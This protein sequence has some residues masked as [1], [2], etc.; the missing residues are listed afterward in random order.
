MKDILSFFLLTFVGRC[1]AYPSGAPAGVCDSLMPNHGQDP[2]D[3]ISPFHLITSATSLESGETLRIQ[4]QADDGISFKG[5]FLQA[6]TNEE[7]YQIVG[8][9]LEDEEETTPFNFRNCSDGFQNAVTHFDN[10]DKTKIS[11]SWKAPQNFD[12]SIHFQ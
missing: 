7:E 2:Q 3:S 11:F 1:L 10:Q 6:R 5:F 12:G 8:E 4:I 9:F